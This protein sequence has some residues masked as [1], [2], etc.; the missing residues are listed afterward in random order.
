M[1]VGDLV[2]LHPQET[3]LMPPHERE[4]V[5]LVMAIRDNTIPETL[6]ILWA[7]TSEPEEEYCDG[8]VLVSGA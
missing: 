5:G 4:R 6:N 7:G 3:I 2:R 8:V 1:K